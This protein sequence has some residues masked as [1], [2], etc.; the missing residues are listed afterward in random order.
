MF[1]RWLTNADWIL[2]PKTHAY[3]TRSG[4][5]V[6]ITDRLNSQCADRPSSVVLI[7]QCPGS[8]SAILRPIQ[9]YITAQERPHWSYKEPHI[10]SDKTPYTQCTHKRS[11]DVQKTLP[12]TT[13]THNN[14]IHITRT[15]L[16]VT[17]RPLNGHFAI[18]YPLII[19]WQS[20]LAIF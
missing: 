5:S 3:I 18:T 8:T 6:S 10:H 7:G 9:H 20:Q 11:Y 2:E 15:R 1:T 13:F 4:L 19:N 14:Q 17:S 12:Y 16:P